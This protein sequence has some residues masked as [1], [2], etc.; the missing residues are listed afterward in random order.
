MMYS[1]DP[2]NTNRFIG[3]LS[4]SVNVIIKD[5]NGISYFDCDKDNDVPHVCISELIDSIKTG[6]PS[7]FD[8]YQGREA[9]KLIIATLKAIKSGELIHFK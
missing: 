5:S 4:D 6:K 3:D 7:Q 1:Y 2:E 9:L 8:G